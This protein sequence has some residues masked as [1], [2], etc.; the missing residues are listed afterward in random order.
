M[1]AVADGLDQA[2]LQHLKQV[3]EAD[4]AS[5]FYAGAAIVVSRH[6]QVGL[7]ERLGTYSSVN[8]QPIA[9]DAVFSLFSLTKAFTNVLIL[10]GVELGRFAF[11]TRVSG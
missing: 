8:D 7:D 11:T 4:I 2:R 6:G 5:G 9:P 3:I 1:N 10:R